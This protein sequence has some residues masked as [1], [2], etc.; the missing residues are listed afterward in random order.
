MRSAW[1]KVC[2]TFGVWGCASANHSREAGKKKNPPKRTREEVGRYR[3]GFKC[4]Q[5]AE[6]DKSY[7]AM[8]DQDSQSRLHNRCSLSAVVVVL[9]PPCVFLSPSFVVLYLDSR[10]LIL[11]RPLLE[12]L[13]WTCD[14]VSHAVGTPRMWWCRCSCGSRTWVPLGCSRGCRCLCECQR[15]NGSPRECCNSAISC[16]FTQQSSSLGRGRG[17]EGHG[18]R[19]G[20]RSPGSPLGPDQSEVCSGARKR[21]A[22]VKCTR[23]KEEVRNT[24]KSKQTASE[25]TTPQHRR[26]TVLTRSHINQPLDF[27]GL[28]GAVQSRPCPTWFGSRRSCPSW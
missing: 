20:I 25:K 2:L 18:S 7:R 19:C 13:I 6:L 9:F 27:H 11:A 1:A 22:V 26:S 10:V 4:D 8:R 17:C 21:T 5:P 14:T 3:I 23:K 12:N 28:G 24:T 16:L 15:N